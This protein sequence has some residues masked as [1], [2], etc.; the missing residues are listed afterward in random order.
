ME[1]V[2][3]I[4]KYKVVYSIVAI[5]AIV[6]LERLYSDRLVVNTKMVRV[7]EKLVRVKATPSFDFSFEFKESRVRLDL[8][9]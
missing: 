1:L 2:D 9:H 5:L 7:A 3:A 8:I 4:K 6:I